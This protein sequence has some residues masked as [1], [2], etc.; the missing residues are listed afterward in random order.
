MGARPSSFRKPGGFLNGVDGTI[1]GYRWTDEFNGQPWTPGKNA[2]GKAKFHSMQFELSAR[3]DGA[4]ADITQ[5]L[6]AGGFDDYEISEDG[7]TLTAVDGGEVSIG[8]NTPVAKFISSL[9]E[10]GFPESNLSD[11]PNTVNLEPIIGTRVRFGQAQEI[12][13][14][15]GKAKQRVVTKGKFAGRSFDQTTTVVMNVYEVPKAGGSKPTAAKGTK[16]AKPASVNVE[17]LAAE[18]LTAIVV[19]AGGS[20]KK[21]KLSM[22]ALKALKGHANTQDVRTLLASDDFLG[23]VEGLEYDEATQTVNV[24]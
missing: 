21:A 4:E 16:S 11:D 6:F 18:T 17:E 15:T 22:A 19:A 2:E 9:V 23:G 10:S 12:D 1:T 5:N 13:R 8:A 24:E 3:I 7:L 20:I 14:K